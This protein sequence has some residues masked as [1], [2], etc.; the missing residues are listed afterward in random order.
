LIRKKLSGISLLYIILF[1]NIV[2]SSL[3]ARERVNPSPNKAVAETSIEN[4]YNISDY[5]L[6]DQLSKLFESSLEGCAPSN[7]ETDI[8]T[9]SPEDETKIRESCL[10]SIIIHKLGFSFT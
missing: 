6:A 5:A 9:L 2:I 1:F 8:V 10:K 3:I 7:G 4:Y